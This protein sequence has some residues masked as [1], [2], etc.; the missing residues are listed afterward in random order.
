RPG[1][2]L[3]E[4]VAFVGVNENQI[5]IGT[6]IQ[7]LPAQFTHAENAEFGRLAAF[8]DL[9][10]IRPAETFG[11]LAPAYLING[12]EADIRH[13]GNFARDFRDVGQAREIARGD[14]EHFPL[15]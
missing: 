8:V 12:V 6:V 4:D 7:F 9:E 2:R 11:E 15:F 3:F 10:V 14:A 13:G 5:D 1:R